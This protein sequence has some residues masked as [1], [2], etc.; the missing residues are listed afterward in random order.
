MEIL[1]TIGLIVLLAIP[2][3]IHIV[4]NRE[5]DIDEELKSNRGVHYINKNLK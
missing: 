5:H 1:S 3:V 2:V 4:T